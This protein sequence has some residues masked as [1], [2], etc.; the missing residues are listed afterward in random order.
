M[1]LEKVGQKRKHPLD[2]SETECSICREILYDPR[3]FGCGHS[4]CAVCKIQQSAFCPECKWR[5]ASA[6]FELIKNYRLASIIEALDPEAYELKRKEH[7][8]KVW[9]HD[10]QRLMPGFVVNRHLME[11][12]A[13]FE[14]AQR[15]DNANLWLRKDAD[16]LDV[17]LSETCMFSIQ[18]GDSHGF[19]R[20]G[21]C[22]GIFFAW[23]KGSLLIYNT[24]KEWFRPKP[25]PQSVERSN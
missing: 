16:Q 13:V 24:G 22:H 19:T 8:F 6:S 5:P 14:V 20:F 25:S 17:L 21:T 15:I 2:V 9:A 23:N 7:A 1:N 11:K 10:K 18:E 4:I 3:T 12:D